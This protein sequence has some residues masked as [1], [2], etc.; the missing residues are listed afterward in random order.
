MA[1]D[2]HGLEIYQYHQV[3]F[4]RPGAGMLCAWKEGDAV[5]P[6]AG[7]QGASFVET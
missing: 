6:A 5:D 2:D 1:A 4:V 7:T 3:L